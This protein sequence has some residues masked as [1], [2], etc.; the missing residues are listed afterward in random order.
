MTQV[1]EKQGSLRL[2]GQSCSGRLI[3]H[4]SLLCQLNL[5]NQLWAN[6]WS[7]V[8]TNSCHQ[9]RSSVIS[10][11]VIFIRIIL[12]IFPW[13]WFHFFAHRSCNNELKQGLTGFCGLCCHYGAKQQ[14]GIGHWGGDGPFLHPPYNWPDCNSQRIGH[15]TGL[16]LDYFV[17]ACLPIC[18]SV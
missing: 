18:H 1:V 17:S 14:L 5:V 13:N 11:L 2:I 12:F 10:A 15:K 6:L 9:D 3:T 16:F 8:I 4:I 7:L